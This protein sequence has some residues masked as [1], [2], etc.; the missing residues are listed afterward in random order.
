MAKKPQSKGNKTNMTTE[1]N[2]ENTAGGKLTLE[3]KIANTEALLAKYRALQNS[4]K[5]INNVQVGDEVTF[6]FG[7]AEK[8]RDEKGSV[9]GIAD[10]A[11]GKVVAIQVGEGIDV[12]VRKVRAADIVSNPAADARNAEAGEGETASADADPLA[13]E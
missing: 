3:Q 1:A 10:T 4:L 2:T 11:Q 6:K 8:A 5:Q 7:R 9:I 12:A 13:A